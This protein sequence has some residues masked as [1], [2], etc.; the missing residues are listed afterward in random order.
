MAHSPTE[1]GELPRTLFTP[2]RRIRGCGSRVFGAAFGKLLTLIP[3][4]FT[5]E[6]VARRGMARF[7]RFDSAV[8]LVID[9]PWRCV[10][11]QEG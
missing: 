3:D 8:W 4:P 5:I 11:E 9:R 6:Q 7:Q 10:C 1:L 2:W